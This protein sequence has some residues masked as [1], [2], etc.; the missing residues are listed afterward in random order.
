MSSSKSLKNPELDQGI[1]MN[2]Q[3]IEAARKAAIMPPLSLEEY[4]EFLQRFP[5]PTRA[6]LLSRSGPR[7]DKI[8][9]LV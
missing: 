6:E 1:R 7:G 9:E 4:I 8:F 5:E 3:D 2:R